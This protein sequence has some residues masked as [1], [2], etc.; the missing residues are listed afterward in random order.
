M[1]ATQVQYTPYSR[2]R[3]TAE[4]SNSI[5]TGKRSVGLLPPSRKQRVFTPLKPKKE[6]LPKP[7][8]KKPKRSF[9]SIENF[10]VIDLNFPVFVFVTSQLF[11]APIKQITTYLSEG[12]T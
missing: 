7:V 9:F 6:F 5:S 3:L 12:N 2:R 10:I 8:S 11:Y 1:L 4:R